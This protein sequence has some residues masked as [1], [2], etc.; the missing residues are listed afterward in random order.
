[1]GLEWNCLGDLGVV[2]GYLGNLRAVLGIIGGKQ[3][4][5]GHY[6]GKIELYWAR[7]LFEGARTCM[8]LGWG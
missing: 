3:S 7:G 6:R 2:W 1:M 5:T 4:C 8:K